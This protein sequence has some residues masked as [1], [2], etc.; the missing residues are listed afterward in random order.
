MARR[1][2]SEG[3]WDFSK[4]EGGRGKR[5]KEGDYLVRVLKK[6]K[7][8][9]SENKGTPYLEFFFK[10]LDG[11]Y[12]GEVFSQRFYKSNR[13]LW[14]MRSFIEACGETVPASAKDDRKIASLVIGNDVIVTIS[15]NKNP[16][17]NTVR[18]QIS[19]VIDPEEFEDDEEEDEDDDELDIDD[20]EEDEDEEEEDEE[21]EPSP[22]RGRKSKASSPKGR[23]KRR[24]PADDD[25]EEEDEEDEDLEEL[26][27]EGL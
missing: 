11:K 1:R 13:A 25:E 3:L 15:D 14:L 8:G 4:E 21:D 16:D 12:K 2:S 23:G 22:R 19:D 10:F 26:D 9:V 20:D 24:K 5:Y 17:D 27:L 7:S 18:S 6:A